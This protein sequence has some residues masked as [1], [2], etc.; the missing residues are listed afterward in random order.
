MEKHEIKEKR[1]ARFWLLPEGPGTCEPEDI[2]KRV[3]EHLAA[4]MIILTKD[5]EINEHLSAGW[6]IVHICHGEGRM[7][8]GR[9]TET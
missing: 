3:S 5:E 2:I 6:R 9:F 8:L 4:E 1:T 7:I